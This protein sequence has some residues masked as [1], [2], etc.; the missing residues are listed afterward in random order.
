MLTEIFQ[1]I[2]E[3]FN[4]TLGG[5]IPPQVIMIGVIFLIFY[6]F[7]IKPQ[8]KRR[9]LYKDFL[10][11]LKVGTYVVTIG[12]IHG[13]VV[14]LEQDKVVLSINTEGTLL[15]IEKNAISVEMSKKYQPQPT[16][17]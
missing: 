14:S 16:S 13:E 17:E 2:Q 12:G 6:F 10:S 4:T 15:T 1:N 7:T 3:F 8:K 9:N 11:Q 5:K